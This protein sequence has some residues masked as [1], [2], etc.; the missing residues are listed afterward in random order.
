MMHRHIAPLFALGLLAT[1]LTVPYLP[2]LAEVNPPAVAPG[3]LPSGAAFVQGNQVPVAGG[4]MKIDNLL[5]TGTFPLVNEGGIWPGSMAYTY[6]GISKEFTAASVATPGDAPLTP[7]FSFANENGSGASVVAIMGDCNVHTN[8]GACWGSNLIARSNGGGINAKLVGLEIDVEPAAGDVVTDGGGLFLNAF[9]SATGPAIQTGS[10]DGVG[11]FTN[12][13]ILGGIGSTG[14]GL[15]TTV[16]STMAYGIY[17]GNGSFNQAAI[18][19]GNDNGSNQQRIRFSGASGSP[20][21]IYVD[22]SNFT[23][24]VSA[25]NSLLIRD[26]TDTVNLAYWDISTGNQYLLGNLLDAGTAPTGT[27]GSGYVRATSPVLVTPTL[28]AA[29]ATSINKVS[30]TAPATSATLTI[31]DGKTLAAN[32][33]LTLAGTDATTMTFPATSKTIMASDYSNGTTLAANALLTGGGAGAA[34]NAVAI[35]GLVKGNG[36]SAPAAYGGTSCTNQFPRSLDLNGA[37]TCASVA[38]ADL[39]GGIS[40]S[41]LTALAHTV[42]SVAAPAGTTSTTGVMMGLG[43]TITPTN[44]G[45]VHISVCGDIANS[46]VADGANVQ[47]RTGT[48]TAPSNAAALTGTTRGSLVRHTSPVGGTKFPFCVQ[49]TVTGLALSTAVWIDVGVA[50]VTGG[51][52]TIADVDIVADEVP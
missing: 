52:A 33:S 30:L 5:Q 17:T 28:G 27:A 37:A 51:T 23:H 31:L 10:G 29:T 38:N 4:A 16:G 18:Q 49:W 50:A 13:I 9:S 3:A 14:A 44:S 36:A 45:N 1:A 35:T 8:N 19:I 46:T 32:N 12:G 15:S 42:S 48:G 20:A 7:L 43:G 34:P 6:L 47:L 39:A 22:S 21:Q 41:K 26:S 2:A 25:S 40:T 24:I 11:S